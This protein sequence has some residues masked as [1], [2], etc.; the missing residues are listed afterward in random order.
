MT[1]NNLIF[2]VQPPKRFDG[3]KLVITFADHGNDITVE[4][5]ASSENIALAS[6]VLSRLA[7]ES[8]DVKL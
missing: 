5:H 4:G 2:L 1:K 7:N 3:D 8:L 6:V